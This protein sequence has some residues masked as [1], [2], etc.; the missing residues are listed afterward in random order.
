ME[1]KEILQA[2]RKRQK[3]HSLIRGGRERRKAKEGRFKRGSRR[4]GVT[5]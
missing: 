3:A 5:S 4:D 1:E 2:E